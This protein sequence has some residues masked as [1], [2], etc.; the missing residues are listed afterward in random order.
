MRRLIEAMHV[1]SELVF[2]QLSNH[3]LFLVIDGL[4]EVS[5]IRVAWLVLISHLLQVK[6]NLQQS[7][8]YIVEVPEL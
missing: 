8:H 3:K 6:W 2:E 5:Q 7:L 4:H 1:D